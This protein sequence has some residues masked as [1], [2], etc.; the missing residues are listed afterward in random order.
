VRI[1]TLLRQIEVSMAQGNSTPVACLETGIFGRGWGATA[2]IRQRG[3][4]V[5][6]GT[7]SEH[8]PDSTA[9]GLYSNAL[10]P[11]VRLRREFSLDRVSSSDLS[12]SQNDAHNAGLENQI[13]LCVAA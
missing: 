11:M 3:G 5:R 10:Q 9:C 8:G 2:D 1:V 6:F 7:R 13:V 12:G 4:D